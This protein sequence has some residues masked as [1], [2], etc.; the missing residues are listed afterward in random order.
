[1]TSFKYQRLQKSTYQRL[2]GRKSYRCAQSC[3]CSLLQSV[4]LTAQQRRPHSLLQSWLHGAVPG[5]PCR[6]FNA[7][8]LVAECRLHFTLDRQPQQ[9]PAQLPRTSAD[10]P[11]LWTF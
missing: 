10:T 3:R 5:L 6:S 2:V 9:L 4:Q 7:A 8:R 11:K 1:M